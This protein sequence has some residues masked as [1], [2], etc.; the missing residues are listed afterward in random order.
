MKKPSNTPAPPSSWQ[1]WCGNVVSYVRF[2]PDHAAIRKEL[3][4]HLED[5]CAD[6]QRIGY[7]PEEARQK[8]LEAMGSAEEVGKA[9][10]K[11]HK[12]W[13]GWLW[14]A[15]RWMIL[16]LLIAIAVALLKSDRGWSSLRLRTEGQ[17]SWTEPAAGADRIETEHAIFWLAPGA[18]TEQDGLTHAEFHLWMKTKQPLEASYGT[19]IGYMEIADDR[20]AVP[21]YERNEDYVWPESGYWNSLGGT[22]TSWTRYDWNFELVQAYTPQWVEIRYP[23]GGNDWTLRAE[24]EVAE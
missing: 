5:N 18:V 14:Q 24:W 19:I 13:L 20:G 17:L 16:G 11:A 12:P 6:F 1:I 10:D 2:Q 21:R 4:A 8:A 3:L 9:M 15:T 23:Y 22:Y 7:E